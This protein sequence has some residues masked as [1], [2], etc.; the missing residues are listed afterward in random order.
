LRHMR[1]GGNRPCGQPAHLYGQSSFAH[2]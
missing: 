2:G 1:R